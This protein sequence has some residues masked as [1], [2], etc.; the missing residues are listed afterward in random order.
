MYKDDAVPDVH[1]VAAI[2]EEGMEALIA[3][4]KIEITPLAAAADESRRGSCGQEPNG[5]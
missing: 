1:K 4:S 5:T 3:M 2:T